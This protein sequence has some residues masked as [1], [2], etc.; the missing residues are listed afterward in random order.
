MAENLSI[1]YD[2]FMRSIFLALLIKDFNVNQ[3]NW[4]IWSKK[5]SITNVVILLVMVGMS[6][7]L[8]VCLSVTG[9]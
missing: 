8:S 3:S 5:V 7:C 6:V 2:Y 1:L 4:D 9:W